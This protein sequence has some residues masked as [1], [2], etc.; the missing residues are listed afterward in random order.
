MGGGVPR[1][2]QIET[3]SRLSPGPNGIYISRNTVQY[4]TS[5]NTILNKWKWSQK[6]VKLN[7]QN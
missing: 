5:Y 7:F 3:E 2:Q 4:K 6:I 1:I